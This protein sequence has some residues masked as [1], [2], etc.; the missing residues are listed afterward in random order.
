MDKYIKYPTI[1]FSSIFDFEEFD[2][3]PGIGRKITAKSDSA[4]EQLSTDTV[5]APPSQGKGSKM[6][7]CLLAL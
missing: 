2:V 6:I 1:Y 4:A 7:R 5:P 3:R